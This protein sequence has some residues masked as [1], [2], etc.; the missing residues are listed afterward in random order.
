MIPLDSSLENNIYPLSVLEERFS[1]GSTVTQANWDY[2][3]SCIDLVMDE[4][5]NQY[6]VRIPYYAVQGSLDFPGVTV[7]LEKPHFLGCYSPEP[8]NNTHGK[9][10]AF[11]ADSDDRY[12]ENREA[13]KKALQRVEK[14]LLP[15]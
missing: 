4:G 10:S 15:G 11:S 6:V 8:A 13:G 9:P 2:E 14:L 1:P 12:E 5:G 3:R 7:R